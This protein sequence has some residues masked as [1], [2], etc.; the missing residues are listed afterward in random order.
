MGAEF[1]A[2]EQKIVDEGVMSFKAILWADV[3]KQAKTFGKRMAR[4]AF[5][6]AILSELERRGPVSDEVRTELDGI[7]NKVEGSDM[8]A[9]TTLDET[10]ERYQAFA[11]AAGGVTPFPVINATDRHAARLDLMERFLGAL[12]AWEQAS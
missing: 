2:Y 9:M 12:D 8:V 11:E 7:A 6:E 1:E 4:G 5:A 10:L 3:D